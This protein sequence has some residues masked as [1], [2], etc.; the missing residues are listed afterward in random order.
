MVA[1][2]GAALAATYTAAELTGSESGK[3]PGIGDRYVSHDNKSYRFVRYLGGVGNIPAVVGQA[4]YFY[5]PGG[6]S[7]GTVIDVTSDLSD[8]SEIT[9]GV[10]LSAPAS[11]DYCW[12]QTRGVATM[13]IALTAGGDGDP[14]TASGAT[15]GTLDLVAAVTDPIAG[16]AVDASA[17][18]VFL[19]CPD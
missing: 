16:F 15:D 4:A 12:I 9:A 17:R 1:L 19:T 11:G 14:I 6:V 2:A 8:S 7:T 13:S 5:A 3:C 10:L 18:I